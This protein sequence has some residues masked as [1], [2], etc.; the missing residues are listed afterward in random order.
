[1]ALLLK[2]GACGGTLEFTFNLVIQV[3]LASIAFMAETFKDKVSAHL[4]AAQKSVADASKSAQEKKR[5]ANAHLDRFDVM[6]RKSSSLYSWLRGMSCLA[7]TSRLMSLCFGTE[8]RRSLPRISGY[9]VPPRL[10]TCATFANPRNLD[11][12]QI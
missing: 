11:I 7:E 6:A 5:D 1:L 4:D 2:P 3:A 9:T 10:P 8:S 12:L